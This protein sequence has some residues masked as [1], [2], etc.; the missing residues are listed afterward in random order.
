METFSALLAIYAENSPVPV[1]S[2][3]EGQWRGAWMFSLISA[4]INGWVN[5]HEAGGLR[6][7]R[8]HYDVIVMVTINHY[9][10]DGNRTK[11]RQFQISEENRL[12]GLRSIDPPTTENRT[13]TQNE[14]S[15]HAVFD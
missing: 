9:I 4:W 8:A 2:P 11:L 1:I 6:R 7:N 5:N 12:L 3:H 14:C 10:L 13:T 15:L